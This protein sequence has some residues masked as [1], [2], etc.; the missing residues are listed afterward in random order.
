MMSH[1]DTLAEIREKMA[2]YMA[3]AQLGCKQRQVEVYRP[4]QE[5]EI[6]DIPAPVSGKD[7]LPVFV[8]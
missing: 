2:E 7:I 5:V 3:G 8:L 6:L 4:E 1:S